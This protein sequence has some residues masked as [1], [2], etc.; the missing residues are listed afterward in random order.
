MDSPE[1]TADKDGTH[2][3]RERLIYH[4]GEEDEHEV[5][6]GEARVPDE[7]VKVKAKPLRHDRYC[8]RRCRRTVGPAGIGRLRAGPE[9]APQAARTARRLT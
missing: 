7:T 2:Y 4:K 6:Y 9:Q 8:H 1:I 3:W 5:S